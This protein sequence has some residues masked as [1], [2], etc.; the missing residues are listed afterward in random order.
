MNSLESRTDNEET[1]KRIRMKNSEKYECY[2][3]LAERRLQ[4]WEIA[5]ELNITTQGVSIYFINHPEIRYNPLKKGRG[6]DKAKFDKINRLINQGFTAKQIKQKIGYSSVSNVYTYLR[7]HSGLPILHSSNKEKY[8]QLFLLI[9]KG[10]NQKQI[11][12]EFDL[13][14]E[15][16]V[17][18]YLKV[19]QEL[20]ELYWQIRSENRKKLWSFRRK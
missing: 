10:L 8:Q 14:G 5:R 6:I 19:H 17:S 15:G 1:P 13:S 4:Q 9:S 20:R 16:S 3:S 7:N 2:K 11:A 18:S 12:E